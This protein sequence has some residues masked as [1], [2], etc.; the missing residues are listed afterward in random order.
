VSEWRGECAQ[1]VFRVWCPIL[2]Y[3]HTLKVDKPITTHLRFEDG[4]KGGIG[5]SSYASD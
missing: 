2:T 4:S 1:F 3:S 5:M